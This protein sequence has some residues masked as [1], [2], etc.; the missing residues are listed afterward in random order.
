MF[1]I[2]RMAIIAHNTIIL[3]CIFNSITFN[4]RDTNEQNFEDRIK[5]LLSLDE[6]NCYG[7]EINLLI[8]ETVSRVEEYYRLAYYSKH[9]YLTVWFF[10]K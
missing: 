6:L 3:K 10:D 2:E 5:S 4:V 8:S 9:K 1:L 7:E